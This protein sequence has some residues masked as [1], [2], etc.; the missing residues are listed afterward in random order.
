[1]GVVNR[2][3]D[4]GSVPSGIESRTLS[5]AEIQ[6]I[7]LISQLRLFREGQVSHCSGIKKGHCSVAL[8]ALRTVTIHSQYLRVVSVSVSRAPR[9]VDPL[10]LNTKVHGGGCVESS[11]SRIVPLIEAHP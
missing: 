10:H 6:G 3:Y 9:N 4:S 11:L 2:S 8:R 1:M 5:L 7:A